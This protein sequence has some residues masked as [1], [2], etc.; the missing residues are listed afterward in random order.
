MDELR[1]C[2]VCGTT[3]L[4]RELT[5]VVCNRKSPCGNRYRKRKR[6]RG[7]GKSATDH[8]VIRV[9]KRDRMI[10]QLCGITC[11][12]DPT[13]DHPDGIT[14]DHIIPLA[15]GGTW[16]EKNMRVLCRACHKL[17]NSKR[18]TPKNK[19]RKRSISQRR[20]IY[21]TLASV[22]PDTKVVDPPES[23]L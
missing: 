12:E 14:V 19:P 22:W 6:L 10:C 16:E 7:M 4:P 3:F 8:M 17:E 23:L 20:T 9:R 2:P 18:F 21:V 1:T 15:D 11:I 5:Q 13:G